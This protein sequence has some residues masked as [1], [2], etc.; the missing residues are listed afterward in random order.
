MLLLFDEPRLLDAGLGLLAAAQLNQLELEK[1]PT[2][3][4]SDERDVA[5]DGDGSDDDDGVASIEAALRQRCG[6]L[7]LTT[8]VLNWTRNTHKYLHINDA[9][10]SCEQQTPPPTTTPAI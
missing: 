7:L 8:Q 4:T 5:N 2:P 1:T 6:M 3:T 10:N 9:R